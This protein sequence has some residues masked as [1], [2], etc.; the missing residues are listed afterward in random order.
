M[1]SKMEANT[2]AGGGVGASIIL[3]IGII[4]KIINH[5]KLVSKCCGR[6]I[7]VSLDIGDTTPQDVKI[8]IREPKTP[9]ATADP[10]A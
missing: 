8:K 2:L 5:K 1:Y 4:Y 3:M 7:D 10:P 9:K 6:S